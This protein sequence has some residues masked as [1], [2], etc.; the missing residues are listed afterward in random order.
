MQYYKLD[1]GK[2][3]YCN[4]E[5]TILIFKEDFNGETNHSS[6]CNACRH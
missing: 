6:S 3:N 4:I 5:R 2:G 1:Y